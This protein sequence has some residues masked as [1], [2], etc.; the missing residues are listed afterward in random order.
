MRLAG[1]H[2]DGVL[3][4]MDA[5]WWSRMAQPALHSWPAGKPLRLIEHAARQGD[6]DLNALACYG[7]L[8]TDTNAVWL[9]FV[10]GR[11]VSHITT[12]FRAWVCERLA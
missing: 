7:L 5:T 9:R 8:R 1:Q 4:L 3:G 11:P 10:D 6:P 2:T 12:A